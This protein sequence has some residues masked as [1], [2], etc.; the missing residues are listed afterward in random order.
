MHQPGG[1]RRILMR[2]TMGHAIGSAARWRSASALAA[3]LVLVSACAS[4]PSGQPAAST[5]AQPAAGQSGPK[6]LTIS[7]PI[8][9]TSLSGGLTSLGLAAVPSRYFREFTNA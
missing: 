5:S 7:L 1:G 2:I 4:S 8:D 3:L 6:S 9:P